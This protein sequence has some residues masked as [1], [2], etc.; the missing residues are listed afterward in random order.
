[1]VSTLTFILKQL[2][3]HGQ[4]DTAQILL[5]R[6][7]KYLPDNNGIT[8]LDLCV[9]VS[10]ATYPVPHFPCS[11]QFLRLFVRFFVFFWKGGYGETC[12]ILIQH[13]GRLFQ[14]LIQMTQNDDIKENM[15]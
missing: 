11:V 2:C 10:I 4:R 7:A 14:I 6:G 13:H 5:S 8:P 1:M 9:Q 12:E 15:V 3:S